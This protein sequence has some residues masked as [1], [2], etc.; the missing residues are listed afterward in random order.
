MMLS[1][2]CQSMP[3]AMKLRP[4]DVGPTSAISRNSAP[5]RLAASWRVSRNRFA[6]TKS[7]LVATGAGGGVIAHGIARAGWQR[8]D[9]GVG[10]V[11]GFT[12][13]REFAQ[14]QRLISLDLFY[15]HLDLQN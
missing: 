14:P 8:A 7:L 5:S 12:G 9:S 2:G 15:G 3:C 10:E 4:S 11:G 6:G 13:D 1:P